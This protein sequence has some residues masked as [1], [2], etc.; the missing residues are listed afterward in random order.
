MSTVFLLWFQKE[1]L[2]YHKTGHKRPG[3]GSHVSCPR[4]SAH[5]A[6][7]GHARGEADEPVRKPLAQ[8]MLAFVRRQNGGS[9]CGGRGATALPRPRQ[10]RPG[11][12]GSS[13]FGL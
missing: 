13:L 8:V 3:L 5:I 10:A 12:Y 1:V 4:A 2:T 11:R 7:G 9:P 6:S